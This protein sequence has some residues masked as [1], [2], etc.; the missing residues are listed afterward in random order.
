MKLE[1]ATRW[2]EELRSGKH[3]QG[4]ALLHHQDG[5]KCCL[6]V[7][8]G[9]AA[10]DGICSAAPSTSDYCPEAVVYFDS[11]GDA[12]TKVCSEK[13][14]NWAGLGGPCGNPLTME[15]G[16]VVTLAVLNDEGVKFAE[17]ADIIELNAERL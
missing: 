13:I 9:L 16:R 14:Q 11:R 3:K 8:C 15:D 5:S 12:S 2:V 4:V 7:L 6:G 17:I 1:I 10:D